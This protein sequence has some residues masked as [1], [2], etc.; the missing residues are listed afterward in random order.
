MTPARPVFISSYPQAARSGRSL[1]W[2]A[3]NAKHSFER[4]FRILKPHARSDP[5]SSAGCA[6]LTKPPNRIEAFDISHIQGTDIVASMVVWED[7][8]DEKIRLPQVH[9]QERGATG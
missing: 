3:R 1:N 8:K 7:G 4:R 9:H 2:S 6:H 5:G